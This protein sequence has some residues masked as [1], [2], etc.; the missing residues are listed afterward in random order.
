LVYLKHQQQG[1][2][3]ESAWFHRLDPFPK[4]P[5]FVSRI[6]PRIEPEKW[7]LISVSPGRPRAVSCSIEGNHMSL[8]LHALLQP[9]R[10]IAISAGKAILEF[11]GREL[12]I[13]VKADN[14]PL[15]MADKASHRLITAELAQLTPQI[16]VVSEESAQGEAISLA[17]DQWLWLVDPLD[18]TKEFIKQ[19]G[20][21]TVNIGL[22]HNGYPVFG[23]I[24]VPVLDLSYLGVHSDADQGAWVQKGED[25]PESI[26]TRR[27]NLEGLTVVASRDH[28]GPV[29]EA[30]LKRL[31]GA[32][33]T[34]MG[35]SLKFCL[36]AEG[37]AD[38][39]PRVVP[40]FQWD[41]AA[42]QAILEAAGGH[43]TEL[44][45]QRLEYRKDRLRNPSVLAYGDDTTDWP[46]FF[47][48]A[49]TGPK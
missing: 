10:Q 9:V 1:G 6:E 33:V 30:F 38:F 42:A 36:V 44:D 20:Q 15:T 39:Y 34:S 3:A 46:T 24:H 18:G 11:Y 13:E 16:P 49:S 35:S 17:S 47:A 7:A 14:S 2:R 26:Q 29:V 23:V 32:D 12:P 43:L 37:K 4:M 31:A 21:F 19:T 40:T 8:D 28:A 22:I 27:A 41:T 25:H 48:H 5:L 45:G